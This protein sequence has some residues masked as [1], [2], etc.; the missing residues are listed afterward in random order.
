MLAVSILDDSIYTRRVDYPTWTKK[1]LFGEHMNNMSGRVA[2]EKQQKRARK[3]EP[4]FA[5]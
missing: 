3:E 4:D 2:R 5:D 1:D